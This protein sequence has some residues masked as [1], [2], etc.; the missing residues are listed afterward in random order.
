MRWFLCQLV[1]F[2]FLPAVVCLDGRPAAAQQTTVATPQAAAG[3]SFYER[4]GVA[5]GVRGKGWDFSFG[6]PMTRAPVRGQAVGG[7][8]QGGWAVRGKQGTGFFQFHAE[9]G[10]RRSLGSQTPV[11]T[12]RDG[13]PGYLHGGRLRPFVVGYYPVVGG[14]PVAAPWVGPTWLPGGTVQLPTYQTFTTGGTVWVP[15]GGA[16]VLGGLGR[17]AVADR[18]FGAPLGLP[19]ARAGARRQSAVVGQ[20]T[21]TVHDLSAGEPLELRGPSDRASVADSQRTGWA[22][23]RES[24]AARPA[25]SVAEARRLREADR[26]ARQGKAQESFERGRAAEKAGKKGAAK[27]FYQTA[28]AEARGPLAR[29]IQEHLDALSAAGR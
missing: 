2:F 3:H 20:V 7:G 9:Q 19:T 18:Q 26:A 12:T 24:S 10:S 22:A 15:D 5:W 23:A 17:R 29:R 11:L 16:A 28:L 25:P 6:R 21:A 1:P 14:Y 27:I 13:A 8:M 4:M